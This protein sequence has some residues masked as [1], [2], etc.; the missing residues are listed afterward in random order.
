MIIDGVGDVWW[1]SGADGGVRQCCP[2]H[3]CWFWCK[4]TQRCCH[5]A[6]PSRR[7][8]NPIEKDLQAKGTDNLGGA[9]I[10]PEPNF[11][12]NQEEALN[13]PP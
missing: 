3:H 13:L 10:L 6:L 4:T 11:E 12:I 1:R 8:P 5:E 9:G 7:R 2:R